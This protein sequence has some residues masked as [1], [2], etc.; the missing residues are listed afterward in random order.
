MP[1]LVPMPGDTTLDDRGRITI[2]PEFRGRLGPRIVQVL[3]PEGV[4]LRTAARRL[5]H[6]ERLPPAIS[7]TGEDEALREVL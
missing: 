2:R 6:P 5:S 1:H 7:A 3:M 4:L